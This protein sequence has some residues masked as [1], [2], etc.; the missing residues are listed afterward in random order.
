MGRGFTCPCGDLPEDGHAKVHGSRDSPLLGV[1]LVELLFCAGA[2]DAES[3]HF[4]EPPLPFRFG[5]PSDEVVADLDKAGTLGRIGAEHRARDAPLTERTTLIVQFRAQVR[6]SPSTVCGR[7]ERSSARAGSVEAGR[8]SVGSAGGDRRPVRALP[9]RRRRRRGRGAGRG[10]LP[11]TAR[12]REDGVHRPLLRHG[13][14][15]VVPVPACGR[16]AV[17]SSDARG[18]SGFQLLDPADGQAASNRGQAAASSHH[19]RPEPRDREGEPWARLRSADR[20]PQ[21][22]GAA[23]VLRPA[24]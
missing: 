14:A 24:P 20:R 9:A 13:P 11:G 2:A 12:S 17:G 10:V 19:R 1:Q 7:D 18:R 23:Q 5:N 4:A 15:A 6:L 21:R 3:F 8:S 22:D 16:G